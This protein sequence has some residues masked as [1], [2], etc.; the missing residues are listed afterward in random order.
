MYVTAIVPVAFFVQENITMTRRFLRRLVAEPGFDEIVVYA[1]GG[2]MREA[3]LAVLDGAEIRDADGWTFYRMWNDGIARGGD[4]TVVLN[5]DIGWRRGDL[6]RL[7]QTLDRSSDD[8]AAT[9]IATRG[10]ERRG[11]AGWCF[12]I[13]RDAFLAA[14]PIDEGYLT[15]YGDHELVHLL[16]AAGYRTV[17]VGL[18]V[19]HRVSA[20]MDHRPDIARERETDRIRYEERW[21][22]R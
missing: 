19:A 21:G 3:G 6:R 4:I 22:K 9:Y 8:V 10:A 14:G 11:L 2:P 12:A 16:R 15:W 7:A 20:T 17:P 5:N 1:N 13:R 18:Q